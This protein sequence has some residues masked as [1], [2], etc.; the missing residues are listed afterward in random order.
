MK[1]TPG[2]W[3]SRQWND[4]RNGSNGFDIEAHPDLNFGLSV[5]VTSGPDCAANARL[6]AA[7]PD[8]LAALKLALATIER[9]APSHDG[10]DGARGTK[11][12]VCAAIAKANDSK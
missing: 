1:H 10:F 12:C 9:L 3:L 8:L 2:P 4:S 11:N 5:A 7:A 6:I